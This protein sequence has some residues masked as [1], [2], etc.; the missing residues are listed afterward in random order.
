MVEAVRQGTPPRQVA[1]RFGV[2]LRTVQRWVAR[3]GEQR[4]DC[5][6]WSDHPCGLPSPVNRTERHLE[7]LVL[8]LRQHLRD[9]SDRGAFGAAA[10]HRE[11]LAR[12]IADPPALRTSGLILQRRG[13]LDY[14]HRL[15]RPP[16]LRRGI[17]P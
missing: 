6:D 8:T 4:L 14:R 15:R 7:D 17:C 2:A 5:V 12:G 11:L 3:A 1:D 9:T 16:R 10:I 13:A